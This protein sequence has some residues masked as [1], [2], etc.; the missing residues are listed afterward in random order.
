MKYKDGYKD[1]QKNPEDKEEL[2]CKSNDG[3][4]HTLIGKVLS[5]TFCNFFISS[6][7]F[8]LTPLFVIVFHYI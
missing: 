3:K 8:I 4:Y 1:S 6:F 2:S 7:T 5:F